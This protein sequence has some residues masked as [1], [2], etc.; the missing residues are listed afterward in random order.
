MGWCHHI[1]AFLEL[2]LANAI[3]LKDEDLD[4][5]IKVAIA[6]FNWHIIPYSKE[7]FPDENEKRIMSKADLQEWYSAFCSIM[8]IKPV[9]LFFMT[10]RTSMTLA[11]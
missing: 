10:S 8:K 11:N 4:E 3:N 5:F 9:Q 7:H 2:L 6:Y 1:H